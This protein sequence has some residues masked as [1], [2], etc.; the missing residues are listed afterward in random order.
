EK[1][2]ATERRGRG[3]S[4][5]PGMAV[6][7]FASRLPVSG[8][9]ADYKTYRTEFVTKTLPELVQN[10]GVD[11]CLSAFFRDMLRPMTKRLARK[12]NLLSE[13]VGEELVLVDQTTNRAHRMN[14]TAAL[15]WQRCDG[16]HSVEEIAGALAHEMPLGDSAQSVTEATLER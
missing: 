10:M 15:V 16:Q 8:P 6:E 13:T 9:P 5:G 12:N 1:P 11:P 4:R 2:H 7:T 14:R 3:A